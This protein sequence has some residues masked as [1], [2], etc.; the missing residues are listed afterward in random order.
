MKR[1]QNSDVSKRDMKLENTNCALPSRPAL[2]YQ[3]QLG[4][5]ALFSLH[6]QKHDCNGP[7]R[8]VHQWEV[9]IGKVVF[10]NYRPGVRLRPPVAA[11]SPLLYARYTLMPDFERYR[12]KTTYVQSLLNSEY[13]QLT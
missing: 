4:C 5:L 11:E 1:E 6:K 9:D 13:V 2:D 12:R 10:R 7:H 8:F 3:N